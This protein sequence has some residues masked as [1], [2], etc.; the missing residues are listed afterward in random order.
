MF[1]SSKFGKDAVLHRPTPADDPHFALLDD[2][3][4]FMERTPHATC[5]LACTTAA[6]HATLPGVT[7]HCRATCA[8]R[9]ALICN[10]AAAAGLGMP[11]I[12]SYAAAAAERPVFVVAPQHADNMS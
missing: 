11:H 1:L 9:A 8:P 3:Q 2:R 6:L 10:V 5:H 7:L 4:F 12:I